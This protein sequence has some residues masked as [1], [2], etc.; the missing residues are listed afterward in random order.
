M[1]VGP[2]NFARL[3]AHDLKYWSMKFW[4]QMRNEGFITPLTG[5]GNRSVIQRIS[6]LKRSRKGTQAVITLI[7][8]NTGDGIAGDR[9]LKG[10]EEALTSAEQ[11]IRA[12]Q[13]R[14]AHTNEGRMGDQKSIVNFR[15][16]S[17]DQ[18]SHTMAD[19]IDQ[20]AMLTMAGV[21]YTMTNRGAARSGSE[22]QYLEFAA[23]VTAPS[24]NRHLR[25][26]A[27]TGLESGATASVDAAD[28]P[29]YDMLIHAKAF[30]QD[31]YIKPVRGGM[32]Q[33]MYHVFVTPQGMKHLKLDTSFLAAIRE[34]MPRS[35][36]NPIFKGWDTVYIDGMA[37][38]TQRY[39]YNTTGAASGSKW[40]GSGTVDG[41]RIIFAGAQALAFADLGQ[42]YWDEEK[43]DYNNKY[44]IGIGKIFGFLKPQ[45]P[46]VLHGGT[47]DFGLFVV[48]TAI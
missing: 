31:E 11:V 29:T 45:F 48:D 32:G 39:V 30:A 26:D 2:T 20:M 8:D 21:S 34:A 23:D 35:P 37:I 16:E 47:E 25:W 28:T 33:E 14:F 1:A 24:T 40:G 27:T 10:N 36:K 7:P 18:L 17:A 38:H 9:T 19:R 6:E 15:R 12:D 3:T 46:S 4:K 44:G 5:S 22:L 43:D 13:L 42:P 41:Q